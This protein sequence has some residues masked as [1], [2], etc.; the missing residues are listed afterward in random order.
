MAVP[1]KGLEF[2]FASLP[3][4]LDQIGIAVIDKIEKGGLIPVFFSH[5]DQRD[6]WG[7]EDNTGCQFQGF[8]GDQ[9]GKA[10]SEFPVA[11][12]VVVLGI[13]DMLPA[14]EMSGRTTELAFSEMGVLSA[15][16]KALFQAPG[17]VRHPAE[18]LVVSRLFPG[19]KGVQGVMEIV[20]PL[21][22]V[23]IT[24]TF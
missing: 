13:D 4:C 23:T 5:K 19:K 7:G 20:G 11:D 22:K 10:L 24:S 16:D 15:I 12:L 6:E 9:G 14:G 2:F 8:K 17:Q 21:G 3:D 1:V 18:V